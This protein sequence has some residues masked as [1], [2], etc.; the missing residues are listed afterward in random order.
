MGK[1]D[2]CNVVIVPMCGSIARDTMRSD[3]IPAASYNVR[4]L[5]IPRSMLCVGVLWGCR[6]WERNFGRGVRRSPAKGVSA[7]RPS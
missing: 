5:C 7:P 4:E 6:L 2:F 1:E 3:D